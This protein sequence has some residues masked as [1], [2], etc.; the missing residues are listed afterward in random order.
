M[1]SIVSMALIILPRKHFADVKLL[2]N[3]EESN[4]LFLKEMVSSRAQMVEET[5]RSELGKHRLV[6][7]FSLCI[8][9]APLALPMLARFMGIPNHTYL[10]LKMSASNGVLSIYGNVETLYKCDAEAV[11]LA[12]T[13]YSTNATMSSLSQRSWTR[14][15]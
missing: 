14:T 8:H 6:S 1:T 10:V 15:S 13:L 3:E 11:Q 12:E 7:C 4:K 9:C 5:M 2:K